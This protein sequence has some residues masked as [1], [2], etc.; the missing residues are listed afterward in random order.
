MYM[1]KSEK[2]T[3]FVDWS[4]IVL[5][6]ACVIDRIAGESG[7]IYHVAWWLLFHHKL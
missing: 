7:R 2:L 3:C 5:Q 1:I 6:S 4:V